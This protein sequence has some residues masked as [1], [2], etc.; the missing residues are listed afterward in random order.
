[1]EIFL[2]AVRGS[3]EVEPHEIDDGPQFCKARDETYVVDDAEHGEY[4]T[5]Q[6]CVVGILER[7]PYINA[8]C[9]WLWT[10]SAS[11]IQWRYQV[12]DTGGTRFFSQLEA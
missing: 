3:K 1:L 8:V 12:A 5:K 4:R 9:V 6:G 10:S 11:D 7:R 2:P